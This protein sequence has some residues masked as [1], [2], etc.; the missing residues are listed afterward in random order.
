M[1][2]DLVGYYIIQTDGSKYYGYTFYDYRHAEDDEEFNM[3]ADKYKFSAHEL[4]EASSLSELYVI[5]ENDLFYEF[6]EIVWGI[7]K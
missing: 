2:I 6:M 3:I 5:V 4:D 7:L 1:G